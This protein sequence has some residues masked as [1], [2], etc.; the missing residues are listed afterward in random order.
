[1]TEVSDKLIDPE[2]RTPDWYASRSGKFTGSRFKDLLS[3]SKTTNDYLKAR[4]TLLNQ[5]IVERLYGTYIES[6]IDGPALRW[7]REVEPFAR[8]AYVIETGEHVTLA[9]FVHHPI[10]KFVG[11]SPDGVVAGGKGG[12]EFKCPK[13]PT[14]H[15]ARF[16]HGIE[17]EH[18]A[19]VQGCIWVCGAEWWDWVSYDPRAPEHMRIYRER[20]YRDEAYIKNLETEVLKAESEVRDRLQQFTPERIEEIINLKNERKQS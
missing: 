5:I 3:R 8:Q 4:E 7:G 20:L 16:E 15:I 6:G 12:T 17:E 13:D 19:Q 18:V 2:Q 10:Y 14:V 1:M 11:V 9:S